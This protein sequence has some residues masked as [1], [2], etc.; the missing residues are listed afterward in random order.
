MNNIAVLITCH[1]RKE[2]TIKCLE[3]L[4]LQSIDVDVFLVD[5]GC[6]DGTSDMVKKQFPDV[7]IIKGDGTLFWN[8]G[9]YTAWCEAEKKD[10]DFYLWLN[11]DTL[12]FADS[13]QIVI[14][15]SA[16]CDHKAIIIGACNAPD[17]SLTTTFGSGYKG[18]ALFP[19]GELQQCDAFAGN[20]VLVP[21]YV[22][23]IC[24]KLDPY[25]RHSFGDID[26]AKTVTQ[27]RLNIFMAPRHIGCC[28][29]DFKPR[30]WQDKSKPLRERLQSIHSPL[31]YMNP[32]EVFYFNRKHENL[33]KAVLHYFYIYFKVIFKIKLNYDNMTGQS[34]FQID[35]C[36][37]K[38]AYR[39]NPNYLI[40]YSEEPKNHD[41]CALYFCSNNIYYPNN[42]YTFNKR[43]IEKDFYEWY[44]TR[45]QRA[46]K[47][48]YL[49]DLF[50]QWYL[51]GIN[52]E[53]NSPERL[54]EFLQQ[55]TKG[56]KIITVGS[57]SGGYAAILYGMLLKAEK[58]MAF[59][60]QF[61]LKSLLTT[62]EEYTDP[63]IFRLKDTPLYEYYDLKNLIDAKTVDIFYFYSTKSIWDKVQYEYTKDIADI[64][65]IAFSTNHHGIPFLKVCLPDVINASTDVLSSL[66]GKIHHPYRFSI[67]M[68]GLW[69]TFRGLISQVY[70]AYL[71]KILH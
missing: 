36:V 42:E 66:T 23:Q 14:D 70:R 39:N 5:D 34:I 69:N 6:T 44:T 46:H 61:E 60:P 13:L 22:Y 10:Y 31:G 67:Q 64:H 71:P 50:K 2:K 47:H 56:Y 26:Y 11:D 33:L 12:I 48:I 58:I 38:D 19:N 17:D 15:C 32:K 55:E 68:V 62:S 54:L 28:A 7:N 35:S 45:V 4:F 27:K 30:I 63:F 52:S 49:R 53:I 57:S 51:K 40:K 18:K 37:V 9:M 1:N 20:F 29:Y 21:R 24:G 3:N 16:S 8:R 59:N 41:Y 43:I 65:R 25:Y